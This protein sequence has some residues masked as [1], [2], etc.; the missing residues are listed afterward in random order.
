VIGIDSKREVASMEVTATE[1]RQNLYKILDRV[2]ESGEDVIVRRKGR[3]LRIKGEKSVSR[4]DSLVPHD[5]IVGDPDEL[6][7]LKTSEW[8]EEKNLH[9]LS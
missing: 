2:A 4:F 3:I 1:L 5:I 6:V 7:S 9:G 8:D